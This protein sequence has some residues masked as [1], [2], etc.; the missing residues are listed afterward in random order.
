MESSKLAESHLMDLMPAFLVAID[1][2]GDVLY[3]NGT[4]CRTL[5]YELN[6]VLHQKLY[7]F[8]REGRGSSDSPTCV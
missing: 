2:D 6:E 4:M 8:V 3:M 5:G 7:S 1:A